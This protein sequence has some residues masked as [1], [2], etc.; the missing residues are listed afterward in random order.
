MGYRYRGTD[1]KM[2]KPFTDVAGTKYPANWL[3][4]APQKEKDN[5]PGGGVLWEQE[6]EVWPPD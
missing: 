5:V 3:R 2:D 6:P 1:L 4:V